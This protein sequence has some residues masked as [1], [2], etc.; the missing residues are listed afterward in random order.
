MQLN[1][2]CR[3]H[4]LALVAAPDEARALWLNCYAR[5]AH[6]DSASTSNSMPTPYQVKLAGTAME[7]AII[8]LLAEAECHA[9]DL[10][11]FTETALLLIGMLETLGRSGLARVVVS[12]TSAILEH[13]A[14]VDASSTV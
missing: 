3:Q 12:G 7:S 11:R 10:E 4:R 5:R 6:F 2:L 1:F 14:Y 8:C 9:D 13:L